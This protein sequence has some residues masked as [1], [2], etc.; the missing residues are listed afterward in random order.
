MVN[1]FAE[2]IWNVA[3]SHLPEIAKRQSKGLSAP[4]LLDNFPDAKNMMSSESAQWYNDYF[5]KRFSDN[6]SILVLPLMGEMSRYGSNEMLVDLLENAKNDT[7]YKGAVLKI[8]TPGGTSDSCAMLAD[9]V[10]NFRKSKP[11]VVQTNKALSAGYFIAAQA[12]E[13]WM[14]NDI[15]ATVGSISSLI[16]YENHQKELEQQGIS[17]ELIRANG[18]ERK[19]L[20]NPYEPLTEETRAILQANVD[21]AR[22]QFVSYVKRG[23][24]GKITNEAVFKGDVYGVKDALKFGLVDKIGT[25]SAAIKRCAALS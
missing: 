7:R 24:V 18:G 6:P 25:L 19:A 3:G 20:I 22:S 15:S 14:E 1:F 12:D 4:T 23:R 13:I 8:S 5:T 2:H 9:A 16:I 17:I 10:N 21:A 11:A